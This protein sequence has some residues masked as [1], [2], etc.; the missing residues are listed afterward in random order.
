MKYASQPPKESIEALIR[1][2]EEHPEESTYPHPAQG[3]FGSRREPEFWCYKCWVKQFEIAEKDSGLEEFFAKQDLHFPL[4]EGFVPEKTVSMSCASDLM[5]VDCIN[6]DTTEHIFDDIRDF[7]LTADLPTA[8]LESTV[9]SKAPFG[10][11]Q[12]PVEPGA[13]RT[14]GSP[15]MNTSAGMLDR[16]VDSGIRY[17]STANNHCYDYDEEGLLATLD[18][19]DKRGVAHSGTNR[20]PEEQETAFVM[21]VGGVRFAMISATYSTNGREYEKKYLLNEVRFDDVPCDLSFIER[22]IADAKRQNADVIVLHAHWDWEFEL[23][24]HTCIV[25]LAHQ[26]AEMGVD[27]IVGTHPHVAHPMEKYTY[28]KDGETR[29]AL[30]FYSMGDFVSFHPVSKDSRITYVARFNA[31]KGTLNGKPRTVVTD[32]R[33]LPVYI[34]ASCD[35]N[36]NYDFRLLRFSSV[37]N[38]KPDE[39]GSYRWN[40]QDWEREDL[41]R[42]RDVLYRILL[43][44][45]TDGLIVE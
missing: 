24:P 26:L 18:E 42:L 36:E 40:L 17:L 10:R 22:Q 41:P 28:E 1:W 4:P 8:N 44:E 15:R 9:Y 31:V 7:Y 38:D 3:R 34:L 19:L 5:A 6:D 33:I 11:N 30:I 12:R 37:L 45:N 35:E 25:K 27:V 14:T 39:N 43:P 21:E 16:F 20:S 2:A 23:Y 13:T 32:L 29:S